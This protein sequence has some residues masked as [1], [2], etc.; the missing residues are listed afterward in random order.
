MGGI[1]LPHLPVTTASLPQPPAWTPRWAT[2]EPR[3]KRLS[4]ALALV[5]VFFF[6]LHGLVAGPSPPSPSAEQAW[7]ASQAASWPRRLFSLHPELPRAVL[8]TEISFIEYLNTHFP[9]S[10]VG[11]KQP[12]IW[13]TLADQFFAETGAA[14]LHHF[15]EQLNAERRVKYGGEKR[16]TR[17]VVLCLDERCVETSA[18]RGMYTYGGF[19]SRRPEQI[20][21]AT[22]PKLA[23][24][25]ETLPH[26]DVFFV[27]SDV[28]FAQDPYPYM[29]P[30]ME[31]YDLVA[32]E[33]DAAEHFN[34]GWMWIRSSETAADVWRE[35]LKMDM[36]ETSRDQVNTN[37]ILG[38]AQHRLHLDA[39]DPYACPLK[40]SFV[41][42][43]GLRVKVLDSRIFRT[44]HQRDVPYVPRHDSV[45]LHSTCC[46]DGYVKNWVAKEEG[47]WS[48]LDGYY[49]QPPPLL[50]IEHLSASQD[51]L[52]QLFRILV[53]AA[54]YTN[55]TLTLPPRSTVLSLPFSS[56]PSPVRATY[57]TFPLAHLSS[58]P[59]LGVNVV[60]S[61]YVE[62]ATAHLMGVS[63]LNAS[64]RRG[65]GWWDGLGSRERE[66]REAKVV[67]LTRV[68]E[69]DLRQTPTFSSLLTLL[70]TDPIFRSAAHVRLYNHDW[71]GFQHWRSWALPSAVNG[72]G[73][74]HRLE[75][76]P[77]CDEVCRWEGE[78]GIRVE[79]GW[80][81]LE[82]LRA[83]EE[84][85]DG[86]E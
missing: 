27:D 61:R 39:P 45:Y 57:S 58:T 75:D 43:N 3:S 60:E 74:C 38:T 59:G 22:W 28:Y 51:D 10:F 42:D 86:N 78:K 17:L 30:L 76:A 33:N 36:L 70:L 53:A 8:G 5:A 26:R 14:N 83:A 73:T 34:T 67:E 31:E 71:P 62:H 23:S 81:S 18:R 20:L 69:I 49:T 35:V 56:S 80:P 15:V 50:S 63:S 44:Y 32:Q 11:N 7:L 1:T 65:E 6:V 85:E 4:S 13:I 66:R 16:E 2:G 72:V 79:G 55:R 47:F 37:T 84:E 41:A 21:K 29:E 25:I 46:D 40:D 48:D 54:H 68:M 12:H 64:E 9:P 77:L 52:K 24:L 82:E 19:E